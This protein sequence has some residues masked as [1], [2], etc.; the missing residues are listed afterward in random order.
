LRNEE[1]SLVRG[2]GENGQKVQEDQHSGKRNH[3]ADNPQRPKKGNGGYI[4]GENKGTSFKPKKK[5]RFG[6]G[7][8]NAITEEFTE[9]KI[10][11]TWTCIE[12]SNGQE[13]KQQ[14][15]AGG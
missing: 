11:I 5:K 6:L 9:H 14:P 13:D 12:G 8:P 3:M 2:E 1:G 10:A 7:I 15:S 4:T